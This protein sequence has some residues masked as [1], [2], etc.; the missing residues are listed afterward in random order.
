MVIN[1]FEHPESGIAGQP[2]NIGWNVR[3]EGQGT[4]EAIK[5]T[6]NVYLSSDDKLSDGDFKLDG[7][8]RGGSLKAGESYTMNKELFLPVDMVGNY[9]LILK[10]D[11]PVPNQWYGEEYEYNAEHNNIYISNISIEQPPPSDLV[12]TNVTVQNKAL[13]GDLVDVS[14]TV[15]NIGI[16]PAKGVMKDMVYFSS[17]THWDE[18]DQ[19][20]GKKYLAIDLA[21]GQEETYSVSGQLVGTK[22][23][24]Y[25]VIVKTDNRNN[26]YE[27][28]DLNNSQFS[29]N[30]VDVSVPELFLNEQQTVTLQ[31]HKNLY[32][33]VEVPESLAGET[34]IVTLEGDSLYAEQ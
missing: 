20:F 19:Y 33:K 25:R 21:P 23:G 8:T 11:V 29:L 13:T 22:S 14:W 31:N 4:T 2:V 32:Y 24:S 18:E 26:I 9:F 15:K 5:W 30:T 10:T 6:D 1:S 34:M 3:N 12:V 27:L 28:N 17:D 7:F 16:N